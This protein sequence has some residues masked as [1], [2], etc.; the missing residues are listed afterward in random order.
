[1]VAAMLVGMVV[2][3]AA[4]DATL[5]AAGLSYSAQRH[6]VLAV[7]EAALTMAAG[8]AGWMRFRG[9]RPRRQ[10]G[11]TRSGQAHRRRRRRQPRRQRRRRPGPVRDPGQHRG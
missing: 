10:A 2:L 8:M 6:P 11:G 7:T 9:V 4:V 1:M 5:A 3:G